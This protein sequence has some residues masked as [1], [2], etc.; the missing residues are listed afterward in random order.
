MIGL[1]DKMY[2][3]LV[4]YYYPEFF[5]EEKIKRVKAHRKYFYLLSERTLNELKKNP[6][7]RYFYRASCLHD[8]KR[9]F[10]KWLHGLQSCVPALKAVVEVKNKI[11]NVEKNK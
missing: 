4:N 5:I 8:G 11:K 2:K 6:C 7:Y 1:K 9:Y 3:A 10:S